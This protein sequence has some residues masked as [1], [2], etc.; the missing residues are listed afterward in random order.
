MRT[1]PVSGI[2]INHDIASQYGITLAHI[3]AWRIQ[4]GA[5]IDTAPLYGQ[6]ADPAVQKALGEIYDALDRVGGNLAAVA[7]ER[8]ESIGH[9]Q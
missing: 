8:G 6:Q 7:L 1:K 2:E 4:C 5:L 3:Q 9:Y